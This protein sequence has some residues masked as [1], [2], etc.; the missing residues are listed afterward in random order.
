MRLQS[1]WQIVVN[2]ARAKGRLCWAGLEAS[3]LGLEAGGL[4]L[5]AGGLGLKTSV[6]AYSAWVNIAGRASELR[7]YELSRSALGKLLQGLGLRPRI[8]RKL[9]MQVLELCGILLL[10]PS[11]SNV[12][13]ALPR[14]RNLALNEAGDLR[15]ERRSGKYALREGRLRGGERSLRWWRH[16]E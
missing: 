2:A 9:G 11:L 4:R 13:E 5:E 10:E 3:G 14:W 7:L 12:V 15:E 6:L 1:W 16:T 8:S